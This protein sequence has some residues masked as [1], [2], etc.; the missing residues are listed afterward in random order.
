VVET[1][2][3]YKRQPLYPAIS[4]PLTGHPFRQ[5]NSPR[6]RIAMRLLLELLF[7]SY[8]IGSRLIS[9]SYAATGA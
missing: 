4:M 1:V 9:I 3:L 8:E 2:A 6:H 5:F 7:Y